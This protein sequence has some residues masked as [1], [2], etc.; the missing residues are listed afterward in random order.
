M[1]IEVRDDCTIQLEEVFNGVVIKTTD[2]VE[3]GIC[4]RDWGIE[5]TCN[6]V[7]KYIDEETFNKLK[8]HYE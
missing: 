3:F 5:V 1:K 6:G 4:Q 2:G 7:T 8:Q